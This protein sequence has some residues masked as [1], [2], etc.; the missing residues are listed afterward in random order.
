MIESK[1]DTWIQNDVAD[2]AY[3]EVKV[4]L[5]LYYAFDNYDYIRRN[6]Y[7]SDTFDFRCDIYR[8]DENG[9]DLPVEKEQFL[10]YVLECYFNHKDQNQAT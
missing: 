6:R 2:L 3:P 10:C 7:N 1:N 9:N 4:L 5:Y 8:K